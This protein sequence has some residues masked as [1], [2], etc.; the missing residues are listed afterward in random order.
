[1]AFFIISILA[2]AQGSIS[3]IESKLEFQSFCQRYKKDYSASES[4]YR[5]A[6]FKSN[7]EYIKE[8]NSRSLGFSLT[9][10][11]L[12]D[13]SENDFG[14]PHLPLSL[15]SVPSKIYST[16]S[17][18]VSVDWVQLGKVSPLRTPNACK[19]TWAYAAV[20]TIESAVAINSTSTIVPLSA[21]QIISCSTSYGNNGCTSGTLLN[22]F[23]YATPNCL[24]SQS[25]YPST[26]T[27]S[28]CQKRLKCTAK[29]NAFSAVT[30]NNELQLKAAVA[31]QPVAVTLNTTLTMQHYGGGIIPTSWCGSSNNTSNFVVVG[32]S[33]IAGINFW[34]VRSYWGSTWG[35]NG[36]GLIERNDSNL[37]TSGSC[38]IATSPFVPSFLI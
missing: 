36:Y 16:D 2:L 37:S 20:D 26:G 23:T 21:Q 22:S 7:L 17:I 1:M 38:G 19:A 6:L 28:N 11:P 34:I 31:I 29:I 30:P 4:I 25:Q 10:G 12:A 35:I 8:M 24:S 5:Y 15:A 13:Q 14:S 32:Y 27:A 18:P 9:V 33:S 3:E